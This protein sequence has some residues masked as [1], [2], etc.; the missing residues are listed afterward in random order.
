M[1]CRGPLHRVLQPPCHLQ[2]WRKE[3]EGGRGREREGGREGEGGRDG[4]RETG[5]V[6]GEGKREWKVSE[7]VGGV[8]IYTYMYMYMYMHA[9]LVTLS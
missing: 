6:V 1:D 9:P 2:D 7:E 8:Y 3:G 5:E 4:G